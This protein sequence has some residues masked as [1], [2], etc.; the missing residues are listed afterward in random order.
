M[1]GIYESARINRVVNFPLTTKGYPLE[2]MIKEGLL[3]LE[4]SE[5]YDIRGFLKREN[6]DENLYS[7]LRDDG[8][9]HHEAM[10][11]INHK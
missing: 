6:I 4:S 10:R 1:M 3:K 2:R 9:S 11:T 7:R 5:K 8:L